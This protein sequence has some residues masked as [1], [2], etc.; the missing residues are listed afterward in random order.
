MI[1]NR[2]NRMHYSQRGFTL[3][4]LLLYFALAGVMIA[5]LGSIGLN[6]LGSRV[7]VHAQEDIRYEAVQVMEEI[8][9]LIETADDISIQAGPATTT[10]LSLSMSDPLFDPTTIFLQEGEILVQ[11]GSLLPYSLTGSSITAHTLDFEDRADPDA[12]YA[13]VSIEFSIASQEASQAHVAPVTFMTT[14]TKR[15]GS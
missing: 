13:S 11:E 5:V 8:R 4:E 6:V 14:V 12:P 3:I 1:I 10:M 7:K 2:H 9:M 15:T